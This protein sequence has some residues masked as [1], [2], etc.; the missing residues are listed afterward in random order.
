MVSIFIQHEQYRM[1]NTLFR[2]RK[3]FCCLLL[4][5]KI[6]PHHPHHARVSYLIIALTVIAIELKDSIEVYTLC[7]FLLRNNMLR[8]FRSNHRCTWK[9][10]EFHRK[11]PMLEPLF[12][13]K[14]WNYIKTFVLH[15]SDVPL[16]IFFSNRSTS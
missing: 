12:S 8:I 4:P 14:L 5:L 3:R 15:E 16:S 13:L 9:L 7:N 1:N 2:Y 6:M 11:T 10:H